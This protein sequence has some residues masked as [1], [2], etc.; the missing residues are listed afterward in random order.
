MHEQELIEAQRDIPVVEYT[1]KEKP[2]YNAL[3]ESGLSRQEVTQIVSKLASV[4]NT[5]RL[6][7]Q[8]RVPQR[9]TPRHARYPKNMF[10]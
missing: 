2:I 7:P 10:R 5:R 8:D 6:Q 4:V 3:S 9:G 1:I